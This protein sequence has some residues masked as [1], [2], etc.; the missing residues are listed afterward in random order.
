MNENIFNILKKFLLKNKIKVDQQELKLQLFGHPTYP[1]L[2]ALT[3]VLDHFNIPH[4][5]LE[6]PKS[7]ENI[8]YL[9]NY[10]IAH[11]NQQGNENFVFVTLNKNEVTITE[12][13]KSK[14][15]LTIAEFIEI[16]TGIIL[17]IDDEELSEKKSI[18]SLKDLLIYTIFPLA[19]LSFFY[20][21]QNIIDNLFFILSLLGVFVCRL[22]FQHEQGE[23]NFLLDKICDG[24]H[25]K[26]SCSE[27]TNSKGA[28]IFGILKFGDIGM[29]YFLAIATLSILLNVAQENLTI[30]YQI[31]I[32]PVVF[33]IY[34]LVYQFFVIKKLC[35]L[36]ISTVAVLL[37]QAS[38]TFLKVDI[39]SLSQISF[40]QFPLIVFSILATSIV[41]FYFS[42]LLSNNNKY[43]DL[44]VN[45]NR[46]KRNYKIF[47][48]LLQKSMPLNPEVDH[49]E[50]IKFGN[51]E[52]SLNITIITNPLC[53]FCKES[54]K[55]V[56]YLERYLDQLSITI[57]FNV[58]ND[59]KNPATRIAASL[60]QIYLEKG[61][62]KCKVEMDTVYGDSSYE[63]WIKEN[64]ID[65]RP[66][67]LQVIEEGKNWCH[68]ND[69]HF[70][71]EV[72]INGYSFPRE[73]DF[74]DL[75]FF[76]DSL[77]EEL[78]VETS[79]I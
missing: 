1:S 20:W 17:A 32:L 59:L 75:Q 6:I 40:V 31:S 49:L 3:G 74:E 13:G 55:I 10:F 29:V 15:K 78:V 76:I 70:T 4:L 19:W 35:S 65:I 54:H 73:Y 25:K 50:E 46:F 53:G 41:W 69:I 28:K 45:H 33:C 30:I 62:K 38:I 79:E 26:I 64:D 72:L 37:L 24:S 77:L 34:S 58:S 8:S 56:H 16:W 60:L 48:A 42:K 39:A 47:D 67:T 36:C 18:F 43:F 68:R 52:A 66:S 71:P 51:P 9:P 63:K 2:N 21:N 44:Q 14:K 12:N 22:I 23:N 57:R 7:E 11:I 61:E 5:A 27:V